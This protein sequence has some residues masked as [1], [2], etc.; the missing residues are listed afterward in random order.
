MQNIL[1]KILEKSWEFTQLY[2]TCAWTKLQKSDNFTLFCDSL[3]RC[4]VKKE[5]EGYYSK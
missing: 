4:P 3:Q 2:I 5:M 1:R